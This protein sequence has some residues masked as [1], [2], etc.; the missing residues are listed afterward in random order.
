M[1]CGNGARITLTNYG[2]QAVRNLYFH[3]AYQEYCDAP[4]VSNLGRFHAQWRHELTKAVPESESGGHNVDGRHNYVFME[5]NDKRP[6]V[7]PIL[8]VFGLSTAWWGE[9]HDWFFVAG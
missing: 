6:Y 9:G 1:P 3:I 2:T 7:G 5:A 8:N 4:M